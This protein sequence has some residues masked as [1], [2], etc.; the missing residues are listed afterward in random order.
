MTAKIIDGKALA[1]KVLDDVT[2]R[3]TALKKRGLTPGIAAVLVGSDPA[4]ALYVRMKTEKAHA[5][6]FHS[7]TVI[8]GE[9][10]TT[11]QVVSK[12]R[13]L[14]DDKRIHGILVQLPLPDGIDQ[15]EVLAEIASE[16]DA[17]GCT[18]NSLGKLV[19]REKGFEPATARAA[20]ELIKST[21]VKLEGLNACVIGQGVQTGRPI[22][23]LLLN[24]RCTVTICHSR[25]KN[26]KEIAAAADVLVS[27][28]GKEKFVTADM[29]KKGAIVV[30]VGI[31][32]KPDGK[33]AGDVDFEA[34]RKVAGF[35]TPVPGG[36]G[37]MTVAMLLLNT[38]E[39]AERMKAIAKS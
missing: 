24:E 8:L 4:S 6:G 23:L 34:V 36:V 2:A 5:A 17:D 13:E 30:D 28:V 21:G 26:L 25:T 27:C 32:K 14:N 39:A 3:A 1:K 15:N 29:V 9:R 20:V 37:P 11:Q 10:A 12:I 38:T 35:V 7:E 33:V 16:K 18:Q 22:A 31:D 19:A